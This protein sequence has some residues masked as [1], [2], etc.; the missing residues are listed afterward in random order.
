MSQDLAVLNFDICLHLLYFL[1]ATVAAPTQEVI[2]DGAGASSRFA[3]SLFVELVQGSFDIGGLAKAFY[4]VQDY[5]V[6]L[7]HDRIDL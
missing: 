7:A 3:R 4:E 5:V 6:P 1:R 2:K